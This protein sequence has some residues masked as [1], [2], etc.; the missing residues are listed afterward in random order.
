MQFK[1]IIG[2]QKIK[3]TLI[4]S[5]KQNR[6][7]HAQLFLG[8]EGVG[9][10]P[11]AVA[12]SQYINCANP[13]DDDS[14]GVCPSCVKFEKLIHPDL[15]FTF[16]T[17]AI[18]KKKTSNDFIEEWRKAFIENPYI[19]ELQWLLKLD[20]EGKKQGN[21][22]VDECKNIF[23]KIGLK[24]F[25]AKY[26]T[27]I[28][29]LPEYLRQEGNIL[30]KL[31]E[32]PPEGTLIILVAQDADKVIATILSRAQTLKIPK[33][34]DEAIKQELIATSGLNEQDAES[35]SRVSDGNL[36]FALTLVNAGRAD[37]FELFQNWMRYSY[38]SKRDVE[39]LSK[40]MEDCVKS[41]REFLKSFL[42]YCQHMMRASF[43]Y[44]Y[45]DKTLL[46]LNEKETDFVVKF[47]PFIHS[48]NLAELTKAFNEAS[49]HVERNADLKITFLELSLYIGAQLRRKASA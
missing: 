19:G 20:E 31:L 1:N 25:E 8:A 21:I 24:A 47:S 2:Q 10:L 32:E 15:H 40:W 7:S 28:I 35:I 6:I 16:P 37:Y 44:R 30:L 9:A 13:S 46:R 5:V 18:D 34:A 36:T 33:L 14:C 11:L 38:N 29:W 23:K 22:T 42:T 27:V 17:I 26:K 48:E 12:Y 49:M 3:K 43:I 45:G 41:G 4:Q 39:I